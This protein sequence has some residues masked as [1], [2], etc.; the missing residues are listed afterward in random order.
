M[1]SKNRITVADAVADSVATEPLDY[2]LFIR[3]VCVLDLPWVLSSVAISPL[4]LRLEHR[5]KFS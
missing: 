2:L 3:T 1:L 5:K 4:F